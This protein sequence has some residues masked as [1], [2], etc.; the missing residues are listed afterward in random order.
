MPFRV[1]M[2]W[3][4]LYFV[5]ALLF[6][7][8]VGLWLATLS[9]KYRDVSFAVTFFLQALLYLSPVIYSITLVPESIRFLYMLNPMT[10]VIQGFRWALLNS[11]E[12]PGWSFLISI[13]IVIILLVSGAFYFRRTE[14]T[15]VDII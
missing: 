13:V 6:S 9:A 8:G 7:L 15:V 10:S 11:G 5:V 12:P 3:L 1:E 14:R 2:L 4:P